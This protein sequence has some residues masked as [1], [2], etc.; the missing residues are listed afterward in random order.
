MLTRCRLSE[1]YEMLYRIDQLTNHI[2]SLENNVSQTTKLSRF[3]ITIFFFARVLRKVLPSKLLKLNRKKNSISHK[4][5]RPIFFILEKDKNNFFFSSLEKNNKIEVL[6]IKKITL[7][8]IILSLDLKET[9]FLFK[10]TL[11]LAEHVRQCSNVYLA[12][13]IYGYL[14]AYRTLKVHTS[15]VI[16]FS[17]VRSPIYWGLADGLQYFSKIKKFCF[18]QR[19][20]AGGVQKSYFY[21]GDKIITTSPINGDLYSNEKNDVYITSLFYK[22]DLINRH[23]NIEEDNEFPQRDLYFWVGQ[24]LLFETE[25]KVLID[26]IGNL[27]KQS[28]SAKFV[29]VTR[30]SLA[31]EGWQKETL[32]RIGLSV[33]ETQQTAGLRPNAVF[34]GFSNLLCS[35]A[36]ANI[37]TFSFLNHFV[38]DSSKSEIIK[39]HLMH[40]KV[41]QIE[42]FD[43]NKLS[44]RVLDLVD[45][46]AFISEQNKLINKIIAN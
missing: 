43:S 38:Q 37:P 14:L 5:K 22:A 32:E 36:L 29:Y 31:L 28:Q 34:G 13:Y 16:M 12:N 40:Y 35:F 45:Q 30:S 39:K 2:A 24:E 11:R 25:C 19:Y 21:E 1:S 10:I 20:L 33:L 6:V 9:I 17:A 18:Y 46:N 7:K 15:E 42:H 44:A 26:F 4:K 23:H 8:E 41:N 27:S 3:L